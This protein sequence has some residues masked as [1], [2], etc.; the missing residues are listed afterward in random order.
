MH[1]RS[2]AQNAVGRRPIVRCA[3]GHPRIHGRTRHERA[4]SPG[5][6]AGPRASMPH[7]DR[8]PSVLGSTS[9][10]GNG[11][12]TAGGRSDGPRRECNPERR[13]ST[14]AVRATARRRESGRSTVEPKNGARSGPDTVFAQGGADVALFQRKRVEHARSADSTDSV[15]S[16]PVGVARV[17]R[18]RKSE[19]PI[20]KSND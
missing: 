9:S 8:S 18:D 15:A 3:E 19:Q 16:P 10:S 12:R 20:R 4:T 17:F 5:L 11:R 14:A 1:S 6:S 13:R 7:R 2:H